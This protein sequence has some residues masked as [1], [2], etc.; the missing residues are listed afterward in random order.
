MFEALVHV[1]LVTAFLEVATG[2]C[3]CL[4]LHGIC[5]S[6]HHPNGKLNSHKP[7]ERETQTRCTVMEDSWGE[8][9]L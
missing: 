9:W 7:T 8:P 5:S 3:T 6:A 2:L 4:G 1:G